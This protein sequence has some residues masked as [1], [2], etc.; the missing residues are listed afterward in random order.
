[1]KNFN[2]S[3]LKIVIAGSEDGT[4]NPV[5]IYLSNIQLFIPHFR[6]IFDV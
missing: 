1:M 6:V 3:T 5:K 2:F 4:I